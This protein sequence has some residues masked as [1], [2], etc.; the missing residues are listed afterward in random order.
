[1]CELTEVGK[2]Y[3]M[4]HHGYGLSYSAIANMFCVPK[5]TVQTT[6]ERAEKK[7]SKRIKESLFCLCS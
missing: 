3:Y 7:I 6:V 2:E 1:M 5:G 4:Q